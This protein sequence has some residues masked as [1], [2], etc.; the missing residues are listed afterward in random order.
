MARNS[1]NNQL[2]SNLQFLVETLIFDNQIAV[3]KC[4]V[5]CIEKC[6]SYGD[7]HKVGCQ[8]I[9]LSASFGTID[10]SILKVWVF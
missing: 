8:E 10:S 9:V 7:S 6:G 5:V 3:T 2:I 4:D 1:K